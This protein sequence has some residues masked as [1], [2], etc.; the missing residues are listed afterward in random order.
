MVYEND[1]KARVVSKSRTREIPSE[2]RTSLLLPLN[3][4][5][6]V[7]KRVAIVRADPLAYIIN[8]LPRDVGDKVFDENRALTRSP[9]VYLLREKYHFSYACGANNRCC[10][11]RSRGSQNSPC[12]D[13]V[14]GAPNREGIFH[15]GESTHPVHT[16][17]VS[18]RSVQIH[19]YPERMGSSNSTETATQ[20]AG[21]GAAGKG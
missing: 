10:I 4:E 19:R 20:G 7:I 21:Q 15:I 6:V 18:I 13:R 9:I 5:V 1:A 12:P 8:Y 16:I 14:P 2:I 11:G 17:L 3:A